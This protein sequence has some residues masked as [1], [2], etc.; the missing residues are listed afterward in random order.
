MARWRA[1]AKSLFFILLFL[2]VAPARAQTINGG[3]LHFFRLPPPGLVHQHVKRLIITPDSL[4]TGWV[5]NEQC[6]YALD[7]VPELEV[8]FNPERVRDLRILRADH[9]GKAW[10]DGASVQLQNVYRDA[11]LC[12]ASE[13]RILQASGDGERYMLIAGPFMRR[14]LDGYFPM[15][16]VLSVDYPAELLRLHDIGPAPLKP[17]A[18]AE[19]WPRGAECLVRGQVVRGDAI[20]ASAALALESACPVSHNRCKLITTPGTDFSGGVAKTTSSPIRE[21]KRRGLPFPLR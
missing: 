1:R 17:Y 4:R 14:F 13:N 21:R 11:V 19:R 15:K 6:H 9:V 16:V 12:L 3:E 18:P 5:Q 10:V 2:G 8:V 7:P 20:L